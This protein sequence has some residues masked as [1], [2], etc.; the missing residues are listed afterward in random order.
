ACHH[1]RDHSGT[2]TMAFITDSL[3]ACFSGRLITDPADQEAYLVDWRRRYF[4][5]AAAVVVPDSVADVAAVL[6]W[7]A[8]RRVPIVPQG[9]NTGMSGA[10]TPDDSVAAV[11]LSLAR[12]TGVRAIDTLNNSITLEAGCTLDGV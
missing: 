12:L 1:R 8:E 4:G 6:R 5:K 11:V 9:G 2:L 10:A 3:R 7:C